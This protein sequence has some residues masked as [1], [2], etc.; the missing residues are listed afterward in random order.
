MC[1]FNK[2]DPQEVLASWLFMQYMLTNDVQLAY[3]GTEGYVPVTHKAQNSA[4]FAEYLSRAGEDTETYYEVKIE[5]TKLLME[6]T[7]NTFVTPVFNG[8]ADLRNAAGQLIEEVTKGVQRGRKVDKAYIES[9]YSKVNSL[10]CLDEMGGGAGIQGSSDGPLPA[11]SIALLAGLAVTWCAM[12]VYV[13]V[14]FARKKK[15][16]K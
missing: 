11:G 5:A 2:Q 15:Y 4:E 13:A 9:T 12:G 16:K 1:I 6:N 3:A 8:S 14:D 7:E 10:Y